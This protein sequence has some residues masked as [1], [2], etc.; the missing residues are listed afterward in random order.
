MNLH[1]DSQE[2]TCAPLPARHENICGRPA[3]APHCRLVT[4]YDQIRIAVPTPGLQVRRR[5]GFRAL[6]IE[7]STVLTGLGVVAT[8]CGPYFGQGR[9]AA[10]TDHQTASAGK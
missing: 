3:R 7:L 9:S 6:A 1:N 2:G 10:A 8:L 4:D 5:M